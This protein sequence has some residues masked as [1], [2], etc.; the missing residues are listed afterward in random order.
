MQCTIRIA[1]LLIYFIAQRR[2]RK[3]NYFY[4]ET[5]FFSKYL[6]P[7]F[8]QLYD[9]KMLIDQ[10]IIIIS[11]DWRY[12]FY[13]DLSCNDFTTRTLYSLLLIKYCHV[14]CKL[15]P[16]WYFYAPGTI[17]R[18]HLSVCMCFC[19]FINLSVHLT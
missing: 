10:R 7:S 12:Q 4:G 5:S 17:V 13:K 11:E 16:I 15:M 18:G 8:C 6:V 14:L 9:T 19:L 2:T 3:G 1:S